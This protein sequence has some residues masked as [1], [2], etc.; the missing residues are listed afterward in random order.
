MIGFVVGTIFV[1]VALVAVQGKGNF[2]CYL[3]FNEL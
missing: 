2:F 1:F 3:T